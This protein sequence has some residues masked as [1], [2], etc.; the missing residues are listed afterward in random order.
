MR[1]NK[2]TFGTRT[3]LS[4]SG[5]YLGSMVRTD[6]NSLYST[7]QSFVDNELLQLIERPS[8][9]PE[10]EF[11]AFS[12]ISYAFEVLQ[13]NSSKFTV[14]HNL[15]T[16]YMIPI[17]HKPLLSARD[18]F[19]QS[20]CRA[21]AF[22]LEFSMKSFELNPLKFDLPCVEE[23]PV[24][25][26][27]NL[28]YSGINTQKSVRITWELNI[29]GK[30]DMQEQFVLSVKN[31]VSIPDIQIKILPIIFR[32][33]NRNFESAIDGGKRNTVKIE[34]KGTGIISY[35]KHFPKVGLFR[36]LY[37]PQRFKSLTCFV[38]GRTNKL[39]RKFK[40]LSNRIVSKV[41]KFPLGVSSIVPSSI[42][43]ILCR[44]RVLLH[45]LKKLFFTRN[46]E[47]YCNN[48]FHANTGSMLVYKFYT[49]MSSVQWYN[50]K[51]VGIPPIT[52]VM[53]ILPDFL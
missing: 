13:N 22:G 14:I 21:S 30:C 42:N 44:L 9:E 27:S 43:N 48:R 2:K 3:Q 52:K 35:C 51:E 36:F 7:P 29:P 25:C 19:E 12:N 5:T 41:M 28:V 50:R 23:L 31:K 45:S 6:F 38:S 18:L 32:N 16:Y 26:Y 37:F 49:W 20:L 10:I 11:S 1:A 53:G 17:P 40:S 39:C 15:L 8:V 34:A 4:A 33:I 24:A 46:L 47:F